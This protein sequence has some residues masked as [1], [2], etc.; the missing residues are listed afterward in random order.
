[1]LVNA[2]RSQLVVVDIQ[3]RLLPVVC[4]G[5]KVVCQSAILLAGAERLSVPVTVT[6]QYPKGLGPTVRGVADAVPAGAAILPKSAFSAVNVPAIGERFAAL[7][8]EG[9]DQIVLCG[10]EA[11]ICVLQTALGLRMSGFE[12]FVVADAV[13][14][15]APQSVSAACARLLHAGCQWVTTE[16][17]L[18]EWLERAGTNEFRALSALIR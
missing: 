15:R 10:M 4:E 12:V 8:A 14:S 6:E 7:R 18:F 13:S 11:H 9:R 3:E 17:V 16:M 2:A 5:E 1:M